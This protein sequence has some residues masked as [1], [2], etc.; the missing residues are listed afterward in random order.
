M[1]RRALS[2]K[3]PV[4]NYNNGSGQEAELKIRA[5]EMTGFGVYTLSIS[6]PQGGMQSVVM[7]R[8]VFRE[9]VKSCVELL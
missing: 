7:D 3:S 1:A 6:R 2:M 9:F 8:T 4:V 5:P